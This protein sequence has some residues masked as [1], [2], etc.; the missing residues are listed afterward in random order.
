MRRDSALS[1]I[2]GARLPF[3][4]SACSLASCVLALRHP[5]GKSPNRGAALGAM[6]LADCSLVLAAA[7]THK[8]ERVIIQVNQ[9]LPRA[10]VLGTRR[11]I[12]NSGNYDI[13][14]A[15]GGR[16]FEKTGACTKSDRAIQIAA[17]TTPSLPSQA[18]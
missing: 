18:T 3:T 1:M 17:T 9:Q 14:G 6:A 10:R 8:D 4:P 7:I 11:F 13:L 5:K 2:L 12:A 15:R 16:C